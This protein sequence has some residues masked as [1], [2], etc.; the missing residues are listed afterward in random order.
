MTRFQSLHGR[1]SS[2]CTCIRKTGVN[3]SAG[4]HATLNRQHATNARGP[5]SHLGG[6]P[7]VSGNVCK[8]NSKMSTSHRQQPRHCTHATTTATHQEHT[9]A[10]QRTCV[11]QKRLVTMAGP[12][13]CVQDQVGHVG[14]IAATSAD[15]NM[16]PNTTP[17]PPW[18]VPV[19]ALPPPTYAVL[20][21]AAPVSRKVE[22]NTGEHTH[23]RHACRHCLKLKYHPVPRPSLVTKQWEHTHSQHHTYYL[24]PCTRRQ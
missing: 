13:R 9:P 1:P 21:S 6:E 16:P 15:A 7:K 12:T 10:R 4:T 5:G 18:F 19:T 22:E 24:L 23:T 8:N 2:L 20:S 3:T 17:K 14:N 11:A